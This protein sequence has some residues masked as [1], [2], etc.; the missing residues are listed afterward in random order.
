VPLGS[1]QVQVLAMRL[2]IDKKHLLN[3][4]GS[5]HRKYLQSKLSGGIGSTKT[6][7]GWHTVNHYVM[8]IASSSSVPWEWGQRHQ[9]LCLARIDWVLNSDLCHPQ[10]TARSA[11]PASAADCTWTSTYPQKLADSVSHSRLI[12]AHIRAAVRIYSV[13]YVL[14]CT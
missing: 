12:T 2:S 14:L 7:R 8:V 3:E 1:T 5:L 4:G 11:P 10:A 13:A 6:T 9:V